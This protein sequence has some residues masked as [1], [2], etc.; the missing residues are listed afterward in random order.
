[1]PYNDSILA[2]TVIPLDPNIWN[3]ICDEFQAMRPPFPDDDPTSEKIPASGRDPIAMFEMETALAFS[4]DTQADIDDQPPYIPQVPNKKTC[5]PREYLEHF[6]FPTLLPALEKMLHQA[7]QERCFERK[8]TKFSA[9]DFLTEYLYKFN[10]DED[11]R[12]DIVLEE[13][14]FVKEW[15]KDHPRPPLPKSLLW[16]EDEASLIIQSFWRGYKVRRTPQI[17]E[18][19]QWQRE[20]KAENENI[21]QKVEEFWQKKMPSSDTDLS[22]DKPASTVPGKPSSVHSG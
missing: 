12:T 19:R 18:L 15:L 10:P 20:W 8:R 1:M 22:P 5:T 13:I 9:L 2:S 17:Q 6:I 7:K 4:G 16:T 3:T 14:P 21:N 11:S